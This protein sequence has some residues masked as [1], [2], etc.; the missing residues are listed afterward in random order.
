[1]TIKATKK[2]VT[3]EAIKWDG[4][5]PN[6]IKAF[7][8]ELALLDINKQAYFA[9]IAAPRFDLTIHTLEGDHHASVGDYIIKGV[10]G[11]FYPCKPDIFEKT[12]D[13]CGT[14]ENDSRNFGWA[15]EQ[16]KNGKKVR[17]KG[18]NGKG[19]FLTLQEGSTVNGELMR[20]GPAKEFY[21]NQEVRICSHIDMKAADNSYVVGWL[22]SQT[23][24][25][26]DDWQIAK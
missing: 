16:L 7:C 15:L 25:L 11:E 13:I 17:R 26:A 9:G 24:M 14:N 20:N 4:E 8:G 12:Y 5:N 21:K 3:I 19:M 23:D 18:W 2:P 1:M 22:A 6:E 10:N